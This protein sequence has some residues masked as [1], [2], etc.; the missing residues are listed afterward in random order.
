MIRT[1]YAGPLPRFAIV[2][3]HVGATVATLFSTTLRSIARKGRSRQ[4]TEIPMEMRAITAET[5]ETTIARVKSHVAPVT[6]VDGAGVASNPKSWCERSQRVQ[7]RSRLM[8]DHVSFEAPY[9]ITTHE[10]RAMLR[11][12]TA[13][14]SRARFEKASTSIVSASLIRLIKHWA[15]WSALPPK[16]PRGSG[17]L[18]CKPLWV[19]YGLRRLR[20]RR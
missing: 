5:V 18:A 10:V 9:S 16:L 13:L 7:R 14:M 4:S 15:L 6:V 19:S 8:T 2:S 20:A 12:D 17:Y 11:D 3:S 1:S